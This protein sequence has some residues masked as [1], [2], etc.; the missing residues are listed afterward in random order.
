[1]FS[2]VHAGEQSSFPATLDIVVSAV[3][4]SSGSLRARVVSE[5]LLDGP[6]LLS[7]SRKICQVANRAIKSQLEANM[8]R[9]FTGV[10]ALALLSLISFVPVVQAQATAAATKA[11][12]SY[13]VN[14]E[15]TLSGTVSSVLI[16]G[17]P[18]MIMGSHLLLATASGSVDASLGHFGLQGKG[19]VSVN[20]GQQIEITGVMKTIKDRQV[21]LART[22]KV[23]GQVYTIRNEH[24][25]PL[26]PQAR[27]RASRKMAG[28][29][30]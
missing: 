11:G 7:T 18:G 15:V 23:S 13:D 10:W 28:E 21:F 17:D 24:G 20:R 12:F 16:K 22:V 1:V 5:L 29:G 6:S 27:E 9:L 14:Q 8:K 3:K 19:A 2:V 26:S 25:I 30:L 4:S